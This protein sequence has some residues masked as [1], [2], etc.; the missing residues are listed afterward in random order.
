M[1]TL[2]GVSLAVLIGMWLERI[3]IIMETLSTG[4]MPS[5]F[6]L[7]SATFVDFA[8]LA[9]TLAAFVWLFLV[10][11][12]IIPVCS[13]YETRKLLASERSAQS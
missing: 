3:L 5:F 2:I 13:L 7:Y 10:F 6:R 11:A 9:G 8:I 12:R 4:Y 1:P